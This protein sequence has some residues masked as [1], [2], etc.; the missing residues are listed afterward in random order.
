MLVKRSPVSFVLLWLLCLLPAAIN[1]SPVVQTQAISFF[2][3]SAAPKPKILPIPDSVLHI[4]LSE[5]KTP[6]EHSVFAFLKAEYQLLMQ[7]PHKILAG[8]Y[9]HSG[10]PYGLFLYIN[11]GW[12]IEH[13]DL[14]GAV[15]VIERYMRVRGGHILAFELLSADGEHFADGGLE[16]V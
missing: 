5:L 6:L 4:S 13:V 10:G 14:A 9:H 12:Q 7:R 2:N 15:E 3:T 8:V 16:L 11:R 1:A